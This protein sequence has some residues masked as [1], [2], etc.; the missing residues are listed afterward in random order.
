MNQ[1]ER[2]DVRRRLLRKIRRLVDG[3]PGLTHT[4]RF[5][6]SAVWALGH[7]DAAHA[8]QPPRNTP[9]DAYIE[10]TKSNLDAL[11]ANRNLSEDWERGFW[12]NST[13]MRLDALWERLFKLFIPLGVKCDGPSLYVLVQERRNKPSTTTYQDSSFGRVRQIVNQLKHE[14]GG[15]NPKIRENRELPIQMLTDLLEIVGDRGF[16]PILRSMGK[17]PV[18]A[19]RVKRTRQ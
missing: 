3:Y 13:I 2:A 19:G 11:I 15:A 7:Y 4:W 16:S 14:P 17:S 1:K 9:E 10:D 6:A 8:L 12:F 18:M 5:A